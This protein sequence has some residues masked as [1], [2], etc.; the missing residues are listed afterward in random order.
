MT[1]RP[2]RLVSS[3]WEEETILSS[4]V[5]W[6]RTYQKGI[7]SGMIILV[8][9]A[10]FLSY[11][12]SQRATARQND[13]LVAQTAFSALQHPSPSSSGITSP[14]NTLQDVLT[15]QPSLRPRYE[16]ALAQFRLASGDAKE[17]EQLTASLWARTAQLAITPYQAYA[18]TSLQIAQGQYASALSAATQ[19]HTTLSSEKNAAYPLLS[20][21]NLMRLALLEAQLNHSTEEAYWWEEWRQLAQAHPLSWSLLQGAFQIGDTSLSEYI[22]HRLTTL[23]GLRG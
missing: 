1:S 6:L 23:R 9:S 19:L 13:F 16:G 5:Q 2:L 10:L 15:R 8:T 7:M 20:L 12:F 11:F 18:H 4:M 22:D 3:E 21:L 17:A 14:F